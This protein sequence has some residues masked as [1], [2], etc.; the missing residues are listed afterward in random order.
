MRDSRRQ[1]ALAVVAVV[2]TAPALA[3]TLER[4][5]PFPPGGTLEMEVEGGDIE[6]VAGGSGGIRILATSR[7]GEV[8]DHL[9]LT[10]EPRP[11]GLR[12]EGEKVGGGGFLSK[13]FGGSEVPVA[14]RIEGPA[15]V[16]LNLSTAGGDI[17]LPDLE[18]DVRLATSGGD[19]EFGRIRG[20]FKAATSGGDIEGALVSGDGSLATSGGDVRVGEA[21]SDL[22]VATS[23]GDIEVGRA[24]G[25]LD[26]AT[27]GGSIKLGETRGEVDAR[28][29]GGDVRVDAAGGDLR[30]ATSGGDVRVATSAGAARLST[31]GGDVVVESAHGYVSASTS[32][33]D[34]E[35]RLESPAGAELETSGGTLVV[36]LPAGTGFD[37]DADA[38]GGEVSCDLQVAGSVGRDRVQGKVAGGG[39]VLRLRNRDGNIRIAGR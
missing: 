31:S 1:A 24:A 37:V 13:W 18:G 5:F 23:G 26:A 10:F 30:V 22:S 2:A 6:Y 15:A 39:N 25:K 14:F 28:T 8:S 16:D 9:D 35:V 12:I 34:L 17:V 20:P 11:E 29:S 7:E 36:H 38:D 21:E 3:G 27:S 4:S 19:I 33:G 32:G